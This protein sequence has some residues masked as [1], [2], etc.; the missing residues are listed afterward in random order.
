MS[1]QQPRNLIK[2]ANEA[3]DEGAAAF[4]AFAEDKEAFKFIKEFDKDLGEYA[5][6]LVQRKP[7][8]DIIARRWTEAINNL[9]HSFDQA[10]FSACKAISW[11]ISAGNYPWAENPDPDLVRRLEGGKKGPSIPRELWDCIKRQEPYPRGDTYSGGDDLVREMSKIA[12]AKHTI[13]LIV[14]AVAQKVIIG[15]QGDWLV[16]ARE[17]GLALHVGGR[18]HA[19]GSWNSVKQELIIWSAPHPES[20]IDA[21]YN[22]EIHIVLNRAGLLERT[23]AVVALKHFAAKAQSVV[24]SFEQ[25]V[26]RIKSS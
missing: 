20:Y 22:A 15:R 4:A 6:K 3:I 2:W 19:P 12:N 1:F 11:P 13:G 23:A 24:D 7:P 5:F 17:G 14:S 26:A 21:D 18:R 9:R 8:P 10:V 16:H 25:E